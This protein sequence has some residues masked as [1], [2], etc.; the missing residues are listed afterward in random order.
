MNK[1]KTAIEYVKEKKEDE[2]NDLIENI[3][4]EED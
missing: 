4:N 3:E 1:I 2:I